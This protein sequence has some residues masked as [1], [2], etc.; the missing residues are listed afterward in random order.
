MKPVN[1]A[2]LKENR[3]HGRPLYPISIYP[4]SCLPGEPLMDLHWH[5]ELEILVV[6]DGEAV[7]RVDVNNYR[8]CAGEA[9]FINSGELHSGYAPDGGSCS[10]IAVVFHPDMLGSGKI[11]VMQERYIQPLIQ[12]KRKVPVHLTGRSPEETELLQQLET[13]IEANRDQRPA[14]E[15]ETKGLLFLMLSKLFALGD[16]APQQTPAGSDE[17]KIERLKTVLGYIQV[18]YGEQIRLKEL[19]DLVSMSE[20]YFCRFFKEITAKSPVE[21]VNQYRMQQAAVLL[22][23]TDKKTIDIALDVG[24]NNLSYFIGVFKQHYGCTPANYRKREASSS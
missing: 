17:T 11:D 3:V 12:R 7:F 6:T 19:A 23:E 9:I 8:V 22:R 1:K 13:L 14:F 18:H 24:F 20:A 4:Y 15:L 21:Y 10:F 16:P 5:E 2:L